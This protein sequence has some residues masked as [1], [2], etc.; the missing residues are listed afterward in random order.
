MQIKKKPDSVKL[1]KVD[2]V[3]G[4]ALRHDNGQ[5]G[6]RIALVFLQLCEPTIG[7]GSRAL[8]FP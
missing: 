6:V 5:L 7:L 3:I 1:L 4:H 8:R 2:D